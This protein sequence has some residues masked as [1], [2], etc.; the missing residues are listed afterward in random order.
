MPLAAVA[1]AL[2]VVRCP[3]RRGLGVRPP[4]RPAEGA[5]HLVTSGIAPHRSAAQIACAWF[6]RNVRQPWLRGRPGP[7]QR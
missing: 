3:A 7:R 6:R 2:S 4:H 1:S 5:L